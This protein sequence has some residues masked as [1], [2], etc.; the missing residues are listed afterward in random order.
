MLPTP[1]NTLHHKNC[2][3]AHLRINKYQCQKKQQPEETYIP[4][5]QRNIMTGYDNALVYNV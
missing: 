3:I 5:K 1:Q 4:E 2:S